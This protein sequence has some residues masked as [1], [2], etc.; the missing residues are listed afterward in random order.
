VEIITKEVF[1]NEATYKVHC[2]QQILSQNNL[3]KSATAA[4]PTATT[5]AMLPKYF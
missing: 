3:Q 4:L 5:Y 1:L 2:L